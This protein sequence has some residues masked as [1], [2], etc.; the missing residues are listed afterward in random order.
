MYYINIGL[1]NFYL[2]KANI[3]VLH[4]YKFKINQLQLIGLSG[5]YYGNHVTYLLNSPNVSSCQIFWLYATFVTWLFWI[6]LTLM[7]K[8]IMSQYHCMSLYICNVT[9]VAVPG[10]NQRLFR[11]GE[12]RV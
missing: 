6:H 4:V 10:R 3:N 1:L 7:G 2:R 9:Y 5:C 8:S 12:N 11:G